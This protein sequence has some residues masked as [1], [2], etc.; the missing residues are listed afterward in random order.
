M[1]NLITLIAVATSSFFF[2]NGYF[3]TGTIDNETS[4]QNCQVYTIP[5]TSNYNK[6]VIIILDG[7]RHDYFE[8][9][10]NDLTFLHQSKNG[11][12]SWNFRTRAG[13]PTVTMPQIKSMMTGNHATY[14]VF[15]LKCRISG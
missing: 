10:K 4:D 9:H 12:L 11:N 1:N 6:L 2:I 8:R 14:R 7:F 3:N 5:K 15:F 13:V